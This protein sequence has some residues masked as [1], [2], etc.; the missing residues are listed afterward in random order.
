M[1]KR[2][3]IYRNLVG[4][5][6]EISTGQYSEKQMDYIN[7][8]L[9]NLQSKLPFIKNQKLFKSIKTDDKYGEN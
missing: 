2:T 8:E 3:A 7:S 6:R 1:S 4:I 9:I 5:K